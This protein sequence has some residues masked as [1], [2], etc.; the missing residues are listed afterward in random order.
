M[1]SSNCNR[2]ENMVLRYSNLSGL[3]KAL[4]YFRFIATRKIVNVKVVYNPR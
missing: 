1:R 2:I 4:N 3:V